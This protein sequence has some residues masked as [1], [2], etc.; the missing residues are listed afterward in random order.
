M[1]ARLLDSVICLAV[2]WN[3]GVTSRILS[4]AVSCIEARIP[5]LR[6]RALIQPPST[7]PLFNKRLDWILSQSVWQICGTSNL[8]CSFA[9][10]H[11]LCVPTSTFLSRFDGLRQQCN[12]L[13]RTESTHYN[14]VQ[15]GWLDVDL[16]EHNMTNRHC[17]TQNK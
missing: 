11:I 1:Y 3:I 4:E 8:R 16:Q 12:A 5:M 14:A 13:Q 6:H 17:Q 2:S 9:K 10:Q 7:A 15:T